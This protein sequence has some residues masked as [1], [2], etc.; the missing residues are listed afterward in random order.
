MLAVTHRGSHR[1]V[2]GT[3]SLK[4]LYL[5]LDDEYAPRGQIRL[6]SYN[7][8]CPSNYLSTIV[9][10][11]KRFHYFSEGNLE[12]Y[13]SILSWPQRVTFADQIDVK[14]I[15][16]LSYTYK[17]DLWYSSSEAKSFKHQTAKMLKSIISVM[18]MAEFAQLNM[19]DTEA[20]LGLEN[21]LTESGFSQV[22]ER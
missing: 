12:T 21:Y 15:E 11:P 1:H 18:P 20:F 6:S 8:R 3:W 10:I 7:S 17:S 16:N 2:F 4:L 19:K 5:L 9:S 14:F 13:Y 22:K